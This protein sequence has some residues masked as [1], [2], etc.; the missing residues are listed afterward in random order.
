MITSIPELGTLDAVIFDFDGVI[1]ESAGIKGDA[2]ERLFEDHPAHLE[3]IRAHHLANLGV[4][5]FEKFDW[6][7][8]NLLERPLPGDERIELGRRYSSLV[9][10]QTLTCPFVP[11]ALEAL[12]RLAS[13]LPLFVA[14]ATPHEELVHVIEQRQLSG[15]FTAAYGSPPAKDR[16]LAKIVM[17][18]PFQADR[19]LMIGDG[20]SDLR[21]AESN[22][23][24]FLA[25]IDDNAPPQAFP[26]GLP[27]LR[28]LVELPGMLAC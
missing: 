9:L 14:S 19:V 5:R 26:S 25:R 21:A 15:F 20:V 4:S 17:E 1:L 13:N 27:S 22:G 7:Y 3:G 28:T 16:L 18:G 23:C 8:E 11:G 2:F 24:P 6:I 12:R 10:E